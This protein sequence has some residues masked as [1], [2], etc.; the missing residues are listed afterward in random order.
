MQVT[1]AK[2]FADISVKGDVRY[3][4]AQADAL[5]K[6]GPPPPTAVTSRHVQ[7]QRADLRAETLFHAAELTSHSTILMYGK[8][9]FLGHNEA[10]HAEK[11]LN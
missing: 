11:L 10:R 1:F 4:Q 9:S 5:L 7:A 2:L 8:S 3:V 6:D